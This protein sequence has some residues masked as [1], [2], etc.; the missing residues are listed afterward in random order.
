MPIEMHS[1]D[2]RDGGAE[3]KGER[4]GGGRVIGIGTCRM[5]VRKI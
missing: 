5:D 3:G 4:R 2:T 1:T